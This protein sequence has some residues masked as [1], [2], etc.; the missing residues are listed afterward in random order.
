MVL[1]P[2]EDCML[3][4]NERWKPLISDT[5]PITV[6][7]PITIPSRARNERRR[8]ATRAR[9]AMSNVSPSRNRFTGYS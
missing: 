7:T 6:P 5:M 4:W 2:S 9:R 1:L 8:F 3:C